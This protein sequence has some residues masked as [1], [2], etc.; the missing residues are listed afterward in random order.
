MHKIKQYTAA[1]FV[2]PVF[3]KEGED[4]IRWLNE[5][6]ESVIAQTDPNWKLVL[7]EDAS[8]VKNI[9]AIVENVQ[10]KDNRIHVIRSAKNQGAGQSRNRGIEWARDNN[11]DTILFLDQDDRAH[12]KRLAT[13]REIMA[14][15]KS[16][17][18]VYST[19][20]IIE[21]NSQPVAGVGYIQSILDKLNDKPLEGPNVWIDIGVSTGYINLT[22]S[23]AV[24]TK[25]AFEYP[26]PDV[27]VSEDYHTWLRYSAGG[28]NFVYTDKIPADY[29]IP[30]NV[31]GSSSRVRE[32]G[33]EA[34]DTKKCRMD[35]DGFYEA[36]DISIRRGE[37][38]PSE[39]D[40]LIA[41]FHVKQS[42]F[43]YGMGHDKLVRQELE[44]AFKV[45]PKYAEDWIR[46]NGYTWAG[47]Y[48]TNE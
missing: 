9:D 30:Q 17:D 3:M 2:M 19:F 10:K 27:S 24:K 4:S 8:P 21:E 39:K 5:A 35:Q 40:K 22:S 16:A 31:E 11:C 37:I 36:I 20:K 14:K 47:D 32:G 7:V 15:N 18:L 48:L 23:T 13:V 12:P 42:E 1:A 33:A 34:F 44:K 41:R 6:I 43:V 25:L 29:R 26:F 46:H 28:A 38:D 45:S